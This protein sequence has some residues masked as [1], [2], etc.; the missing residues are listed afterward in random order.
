MSAPLVTTATTADLVGDPERLEVWTSAY[1]ADG[2]LL[3]H[4]MARNAESVRALLADSPQAELVYLRG[5]GVPERVWRD[6]VT[7]AWRS[8]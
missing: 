3:F 2:K 7:R 1:G 4:V 8:R 5:P 6:A